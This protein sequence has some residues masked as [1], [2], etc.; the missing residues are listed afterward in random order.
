VGPLLFALRIA[1]G[2]AWAAIYTAGM[3][4]TIAT[5]PPGRL[6]QAIGYWGVANLAMN[7]VAPATAEIVANR[8]GFTPVFVVA[9][10]TGV[11]GFA[12][13]WALP[14]APPA[15]TNGVGMWTVLRKRQSL[16]M[17]AIVAIWGGAFGAM[18]V[19]PQPFALSL[20]VTQV[21]GF[22]V[23]YTI[24]AVF[25]RL[26]TGNAVDRIGRATVSVASLTLYAAV[27]LATQWLRAGWLEP[28]GAALG[29]AH[30]FF[31]P[32]YNALTVG[33][34]LPEERGKL[35]ALS[36]AAFNGGFALSSV[37]LGTIAERD[38]YPHAFLLDGLVT[39]GGVALLLMSVRAWQPAKIGSKLPDA[40]RSPSSSPRR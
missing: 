27:V 3:M 20:G 6:A 16:V 26:G 13:A 24:T 25:A 40:C 28:L 15:H 23:A 9:C 30:G 4:L 2:V 37:A 31:F 33:R 39:L 11:L 18:F 35:V 7:A 22:F 34:A 36:N 29:L 8:A 21:R 32:A 10:V 19:F 12:V 5:S 38:G 14:D 1:Q 17:V